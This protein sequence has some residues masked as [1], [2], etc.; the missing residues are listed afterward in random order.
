MP[1]RLTMS[2]DVVR[3]NRTVGI[4]VGIDANDFEGL[5]LQLLYGAAE[6]GVGFAL[7]FR[8]GVIG[9]LFE[10]QRNGVDAVSLGA[11]QIVVGVSR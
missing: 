4:E 7:K 10:G 2:D 3:L 6:D 1:D 9:A 11:R 5:I 8:R